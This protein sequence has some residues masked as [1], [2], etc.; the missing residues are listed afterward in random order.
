M[1]SKERFSIITTTMLFDLRKDLGRSVLLLEFMVMELISWNG[2]VVRM[3]ILILLAASDNEF[4]GYLASPLGKI[5][6]G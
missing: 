6:R 5:V 4:S 1:L 2:G 3:L